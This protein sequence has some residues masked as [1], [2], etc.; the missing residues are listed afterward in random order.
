MTSRQA[1]STKRVTSTVGVSLTGRIFAHVFT[2][3][4]SAHIVP[5][6]TGRAWPRHRV[7]LERARLPPGILAYGQ[8]ASQDS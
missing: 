3:T 6:H 2:C 5:D 4:A 7:S 1:M 8:K